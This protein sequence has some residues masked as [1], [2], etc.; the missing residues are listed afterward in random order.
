MSDFKAKMQQ[1]QRKGKEKGKER[2]GREAR[3]KE[4]RGDSPYH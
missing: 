1:K 3:K 4:E 2:K